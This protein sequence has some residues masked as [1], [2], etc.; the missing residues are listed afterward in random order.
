MYKNESLACGTELFPALLGNLVPLFGSW[1]FEQVFYFFPAQIFS[2]IC[3][4]SLEKN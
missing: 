1:T 3:L 4:D 2:S